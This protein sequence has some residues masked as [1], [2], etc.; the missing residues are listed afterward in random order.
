MQPPEPARTGPS[1]TLHTLDARVL[2]LG[3]DL[4]ADD[5]FGFHVARELRRE[6]EEAGSSRIDIVETPEMGFA[7]LD[8]LQ[9]VRHLV[10]V[11][12]V[13][14]GRAAPGTIFVIEEAEDWKMASGT[15]IH[16]VGL[17]EALQA[18]RAL[19]LSLAEHVVIVAVEAADVV[20]VGGPMTTAIEAALP[21]VVSKVR[22]LLRGMVDATAEGR[23]E[24]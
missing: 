21:T 16:Y 6:L 18:G 13:V 10:V 5:G 23:L 9:G 22:T 17:F 1:G 15:S 11:D 24:D 2:C 7:L 3:N 20:T 14:T 8:H 19:D 12:T 4:L